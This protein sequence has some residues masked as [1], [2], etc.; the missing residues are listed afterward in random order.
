MLCRFGV[1][2]MECIIPKEKNRDEFYKRRTVSFY[3]IFKYWKSGSCWDSLSFKNSLWL[4]CCWLVYCSVNLWVIKF[5]S[6][7]HGKVTIV[8]E[9]HSKGPIT[10]TGDLHSQWLHSKWLSNHS[11]TYH[12][13]NSISKEYVGC[14][15]EQMGFYKICEW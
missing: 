1:V 15:I 10:D 4:Q 5:H 9:T 12:K 6:C 2:F 14:F 13:R 7:K 8:N 3:Q 11:K